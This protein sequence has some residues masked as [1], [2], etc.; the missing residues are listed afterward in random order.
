MTTATVEQGVDAVAAALALLE[1]VPGLDDGAFRVLEVHGPITAVVLDRTL[2][3]HTPLRQLADELVPLSGPDR[4]REVNVPSAS[5]PNSFGPLDQSPSRERSPHSSQIRS[6][7]W[8]ARSSRRDPCRSL[9]AR[10]DHSPPASA[11]RIRA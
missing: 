2:M 3:V 9:P 4:K 8:I 1:E 11:R 6:P 10:M 5:S 7:A